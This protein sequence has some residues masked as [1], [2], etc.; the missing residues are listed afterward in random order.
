M[1]WLKMIGF[2][3]LCAVMVLILRQMNPQMAG[4]LMAISGVLLI[5]MI[6]PEIASFVE[7]IKGFLN[8]LSMDEQYFRVLLKAMGIILVTQF[9]AQICRDLDA[10]SVAVR[11]ELCGRIAL[12]SV[13]VPVFMQLTDM[14]VSILK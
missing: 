14:A 6:L 9:A 7:S 13:T 10:P 2:C 8:S 5:G 11:T 3:L 1:D 4:I 12:L